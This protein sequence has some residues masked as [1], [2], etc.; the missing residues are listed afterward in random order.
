M[1]TFNMVGGSGGTINLKIVRL[2]S[3]TLKVSYNRTVNI[4]YGCS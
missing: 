1:M 2:D 4:T 3:K